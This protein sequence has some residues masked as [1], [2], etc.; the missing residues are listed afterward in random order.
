[1]NWLKVGIGI[2][3]LVMAARQW[4]KRPRDGETTK[5][6][7]WMA[8]ID[9]VT[10]RRSLGLGLALSAVN[11]KNLALTMAAAA[12]I[13]EAGVSEGDEVRAVAMFVVLGSATVVGV[14]VAFLISANRAARPLDAL[15]QFMIRHNAV[16]MTIVLAL[17]G[18]KFVFDGITAARS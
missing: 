11:P 17:L 2:L 9:S 16:I 18:A 4:S 7:K 10:P 3:F 1:M 12:S 15:K 14:V 8:T 13:A 6:P 5:M